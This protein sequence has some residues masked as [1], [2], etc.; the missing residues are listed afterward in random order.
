MKLFLSLDLVKVTLLNGND[1]KCVGNQITV[2]INGKSQ[3]GSPQICY[4]QTKGQILAGSTT[5]WNAKDLGSKCRKTLFDPDKEMEVQVRTFGAKGNSFCPIKV[6]L[7]ILDIVSSTP[8]Y[9]C[10]KMTKK[11]SFKQNNK[12]KYVA[13]EESC[14]LN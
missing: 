10:S 4:S 11:E 7:E 8:R 6:E 9:F 12:D 13:N 14:F 3:E 5:I 2:A 1:N